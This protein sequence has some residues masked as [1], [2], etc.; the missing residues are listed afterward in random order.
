MSWNIHQFVE[1][2]L[3]AELMITKNNRKLHEAAAKDVQYDTDYG[4]SLE[5]TSQHDI[6]VIS[7]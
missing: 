3:F 4:G 7:A 1:A 5:V 6:A 2:T